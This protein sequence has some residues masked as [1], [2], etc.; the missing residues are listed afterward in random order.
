VFIF[1]LELKIGDKYFKKIL[2]K[3]LLLQA[4]LVDFN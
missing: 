4:R 1:T 3:V 2:K